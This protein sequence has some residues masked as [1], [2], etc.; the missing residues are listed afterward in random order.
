MYIERMNGNRLKIRSVS[1]C[2]FKKVLNLQLKMAAFFKNRILTRYMH[3]D[4]SDNLK[5]F[6]KY[7]LVFECLGYPY[8][9]S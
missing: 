7:L 8:V 5:I 9:F 1:L 3:V 6:M 2:E 4:L